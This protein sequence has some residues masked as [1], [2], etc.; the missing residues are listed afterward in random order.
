VPPSYL[1]G[2]PERPMIDFIDAIRANKMPSPNFDDGMRCQEVIDAIAISAQRGTLVEL[3]LP[4][5]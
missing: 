4:L 2:N 5:D 3:P 1:A